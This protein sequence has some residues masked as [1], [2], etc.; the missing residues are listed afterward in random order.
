MYFC[1]LYCGKGQCTTIADGVIWFCG[2]SPMRLCGTRVYGSGCLNER[3]RGGGGEGTGPD[4]RGGGRAERSGGTWATPPP[5]DAVG[6]RWEGGGP[7][8]PHPPS[9]ALPE[10]YTN[11][12]TAAQFVFVLR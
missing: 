9:V 11:N 5:K 8:I 2:T 7:P 12:Y 1:S 4:K 6:G 10:P 3:E